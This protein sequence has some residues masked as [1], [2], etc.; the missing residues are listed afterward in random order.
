MATDWPS[1]IAN[2]VGVAMAVV[3]AAA[4]VVVTYELV[5]HWAVP[6]A[7]D[8][9]AFKLE[10]FVGLMAW[11]FAISLL[12]ERAIEV[13]VAMFREEKAD[14]LDAE[15]KVLDVPGA[16]PTDPKL[17]EVRKL[18]AAHTAGTKQLAM[19]IGFAGGIFI[20]LGGVRALHA[21]IGPALNTGRV[22]TVADI[23]VTGAVIAG[24]SK[25]IHQ[26]ANAYTGFMDALNAR[27]AKAAADATKTP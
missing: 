10:D 19:T 7:L 12:V 14:R 21:L 9:K 27:T 22:F 4:F 20:S 8:F 17:L 16:A 15:L 5:R 1:E 26:L 11:L 13:V 25:G 23:L 2:F 18:S 3:V 6:S 24:G